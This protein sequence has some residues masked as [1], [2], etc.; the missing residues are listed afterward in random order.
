M[1]MIAD[2]RFDKLFA[3][4]FAET[5]S[6]LKLETRQSHL[7]ENDYFPNRAILD[8]TLLWYKK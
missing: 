3:D 6:K 4:Y 1:K 5:L 7:L 8:N 2:G